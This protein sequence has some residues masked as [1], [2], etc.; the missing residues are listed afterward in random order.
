M[1]TRAAVLLEPGRGTGYTVEEIELGEPRGDE[2][3]VRIVAAGLCHT[4]DHV[5]TG[6]L[7]LPF[8]PLVGGHEGA[9]IVEAIGPQVR[10]LRPGDHVVITPAA[11]GRCRECRAGHGNTCLVGPQAI[12]SGPNLS[13]GSWRRHR[14]GGEPVGAFGQ[15]G[16][17]AEHAVVSEASCVGIDRDVPLARAALVGCGVA[18]GWGAARYTAET[19]PGDVVV[20]VGVGG[21]GINAVQG[22]RM[23]GADAI[24]AVELSEWKRREAS[25]FGATHAAA[26]LEEAAEVVAQLTEGRMADRAILA[27]GTPTSAQLAQTIGLTGRRGVT[28]L[29]AVPPS[30]QELALDLGGF[31]FEEKQL[32]GS[33]LG[34]VD[35]RA[36]IPRLLEHCARGELLLDELVTRTYRLDEINDGYRDAR[37]GRVLRGQ[38]VF[39]EDRAREERR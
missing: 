27:T 32:R 37:A 17:F 19:Q 2:L 18:T 12:V 16:T 33:L 11:C 22:A 1:R 15:L 35:P 28:V 6:E 7:T 39:D 31:L 21:V 3:R 25:T 4:D 38:I 13:D 20:V 30:G 24:V 10:D 9:G 8:S 29:T 5:D 23:A 36:D 14:L 34:S 26:D